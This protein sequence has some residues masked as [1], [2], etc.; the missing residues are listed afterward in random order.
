MHDGN[1]VVRRCVLH[2]CVTRSSSPF[3]SSLSLHPFCCRPSRVDLG[4]SKMGLVDSW[5]ALF[6]RQTDFRAR[7]AVVGLVAIRFA[8]LGSFCVSCYGIAADV[9]YYGIVITI[10]G[11][12]VSYHMCFLCFGGHRNAKVTVTV[13]AVNCR[14]G[15]WRKR[16]IRPKRGGY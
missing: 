5:L 13:S 4:V 1:G 14:V 12:I 15:N 10:V 3:P 7:F 16:Q 2:A 8:A 6:C 9:G 11:I